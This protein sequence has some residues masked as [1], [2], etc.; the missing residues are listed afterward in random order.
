[1]TESADGGQIDGENNFDGPVCRTCGAESGKIYRCTECGADLV[2]DGGSG[3][4][5]VF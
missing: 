1:M 5:S 3:G 4:Y 2:R